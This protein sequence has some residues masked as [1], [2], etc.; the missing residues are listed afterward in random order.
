MKIKQA[1]TSL[2]IT[3]EPGAEARLLR[4]LRGKRFRADSKLVRTEL[5]TGPSLY[6]DL[7]AEG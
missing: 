7:E 2:V 1:G 5:D 4:S 6:L 3:A